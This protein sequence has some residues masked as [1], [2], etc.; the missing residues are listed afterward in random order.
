MDLNTATKN[1]VSFLARVL[2]SG[3]LLWYLFSKIDLSRIWAVLR[4]AQISFLVYAGAV[5]FCINL[6]SCINKSLCYSGIF[7]SSCCPSLYLLLSYSIAAL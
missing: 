4:T 5:F 1:I 2:F 3:L 6:I 7:N